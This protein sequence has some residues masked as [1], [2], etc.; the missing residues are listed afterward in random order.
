[1]T[2]IEKLRRFLKNPPKGWSEMDRKSRLATAAKVTGM[3]PGSLVVTI[4]TTPDVRPGFG[5]PKTTK[6]RPAKA[7]KARAAQEKAQG[8][9]RANGA[10]QAALNAIDLLGLEDL[11]IVS[12]HF[13]QAIVRKVRERRQ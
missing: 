3:T 12:H 2:K 6:K 4:S 5:L 9:G 8:R 10:V 1:M 7:A 13:H 11:L